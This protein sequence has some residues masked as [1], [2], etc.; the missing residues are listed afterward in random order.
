MVIE[1]FDLPSTLQ[2]QALDSLEF[3][4]TDSDSLDYETD[5]E[6]PKGPNAANSSH[7]TPPRTSIR[8]NSP[9]A[10]ALCFSA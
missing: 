7:A 1:V 4:V 2:E 8:S 6:G 9:N 5:V 10:F 3:V